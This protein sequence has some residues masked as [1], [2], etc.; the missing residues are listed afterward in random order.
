M[1]EKR[2]KSRFS[3]RHYYTFPPSSYHDYVE[4]LQN[5]LLLS[6]ADV[7]IKLLDGAF[8][9]SDSDVRAAFMDEFN[10]RVKVSTVT[11]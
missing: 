7:G 9:G 11:H 6:P 8:M 10:R 4:I 2:V 1:L 5:A 3:H